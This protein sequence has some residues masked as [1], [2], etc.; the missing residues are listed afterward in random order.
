MRE[1]YCCRNWLGR[2]LV[3]FR[4]LVFFV[5]ELFPSM[6]REK[7]GQFESASIAA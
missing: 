4:R 6:R 7:R 3:L 1:V 5:V 2:Q